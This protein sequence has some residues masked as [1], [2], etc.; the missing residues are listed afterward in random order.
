M[1]PELD[2]LLCNRYP[3]IFR[4]RYGSQPLTGIC[5]GIECEDGWFNIIDQ[6]CSLIQWHIDGTRQERA[7]A[8]LF[9]RALSRAVKGDRE[10]LV[11]YHVGANCDNPQ[12]V[13]W[14]RRVVDEILTDPEPQAKLVPEACEQVVAT[15]VKEKFGALRFY[16]RGGD[17]ETAAMIQLAQALSSV[18][19]EECG[20]PGR[21]RNH[22]WMKTRCD[23]CDANHS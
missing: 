14:S 4:N 20:N 21:I 6:L 13:D 18:T 7:D 1:S 15:Q 22:G 12:Y 11:R 8:I 5:W 10:A 3:K 9:N 2:E 17:A 23:S 16:A 19:C